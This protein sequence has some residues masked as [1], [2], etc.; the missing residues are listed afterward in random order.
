MEKISTKEAL[1]RAITLLLE[2]E[3]TNHPSWKD[4]GF[5]ARLEKFLHETEIEDIDPGS[6]VE[7]KQTDIRWHDYV[8]AGVRGALSNP[9]RV[10]VGG[11]EKDIVL[12]ADHLLA[13]A[14]K[15]EV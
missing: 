1:T 12:L 3:K 7:E 6:P 10:A 14:K 15:R 11:I 2:V 5:P 9:S 4:G 8:V 13:E